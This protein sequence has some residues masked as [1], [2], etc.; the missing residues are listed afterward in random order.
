MFD[1]VITSVVISF[2]LRQIEKFQKTIEW[3]VVKV[4][5]EK[6][7]RALVPGTWFDD[8]AVVAV[9]YI[10]DTM[11]TAL[12]ATEEFDAILKL[13]ADKEYE[14]AGLKLKDLL[15]C[16]WSQNCDNA[17]AKKMVLA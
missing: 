11:Q 1:R 8:E 5:A 10:I 4:D 7:V 14:N 6:R 2:L 15:V 3:A 9:N 13:L 12:G 16:S 17:K